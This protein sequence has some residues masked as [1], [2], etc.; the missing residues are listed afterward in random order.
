M[1]R[2]I[3]LIGAA[4]VAISA[5]PAQ[6]LQQPAEQSDKETPPAAPKKGAAAPDGTAEIVV[7]AERRAESVQSLPVAISAYSADTL[8]DRGVVNLNSLSQLSPSV[9]VPGS[10]NG[11]L[12][13][14]V[15]LRGIG[16]FGGFEP[17]V[18]M[19]QDGVSYATRR[20]GTLDF[21]DVERV[22]VL[23]GPQGTLGGRNATAG[24]VYIIS[25]KPSA[26]TG[27]YIN[28]TLGNYDRIALEGAITGP[29][30]GDKLLGR[31]AVQV[32]HADGWFVNE[33]THQGY[34]GIDK[35]QA[36]LTLLAKPSDT[37]EATLILQGRIDEAL[38][39]LVSFGRSR[40][41]QPSFAEANGAREFDLKTK[42]FV[43]DQTDIRKDKFFQGT[44][45]VA[46][47]ISD[48]T[49]LTSTTGY[50][51]S[52]VLFNW[53]QDS[54]EVFNVAWPKARKMPVWQASQE[55]TL[56]GKLTDRLDY[57]VGGLFLKYDYEL[58]GNVVFAGFGFPPEGLPFRDQQK[59]SSWS[60]FAQL[61][62]DVTD[63]VRLTAGARYTHDKK[64]DR[65]SLGGANSA[66]Q[67]SW[68]ALDTARVDRLEA[69]RRVDALRNG[70]ERIQVRRI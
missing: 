36:R 19:V 40:P 45:R 15:A 62:Y 28:A 14:N 51:K 35:R 65:A 30:A 16:S 67:N 4:A 53:D 61:R 52:H 70:V 66:G 10:A 55:L 69:E 57:I 43:S 26:T 68:S 37:L 34:G 22:E 7:T 31:L 23:R 41:D 38:P 64:S 5:V 3:F 49:T 13:V 27:G 11:G 47:D 9:R 50:V 1:K 17:A 39:A 2:T 56:S 29:I 54:T 48:T 6:A 58:H 42:S 60:G 18:A 32:D 63:K 59:L 33:R 25:A 8:K 24:G 46:W 44:L 20:I 12:A 21:F